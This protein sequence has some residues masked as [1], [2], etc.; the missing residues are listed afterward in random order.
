MIGGEI[1]QSIQHVMDVSLVVLIL[2]TKENKFA[3]PVIKT[4]CIIPF[5]LFI[6]IWQLSI[7]DSSAYPETCIQFILNGT[8]KSIAPDVYSGCFCNAIIELC[9]PVQCAVFGSAC[10]HPF[11][12]YSE[13]AD[14]RI[15]INRGI[16]SSPHS[17][18]A[19]FNETTFGYIVVVFEMCRIYKVYVSSSGK[20]EIIASFSY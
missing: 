3:L 4:Y 1:A 7:S 14:K 20:N 19:I 2:Y 12:T 15:G 17:A 13:I 8:I 5:I 10:W 16:V 6:V 11:I 9:I 18:D